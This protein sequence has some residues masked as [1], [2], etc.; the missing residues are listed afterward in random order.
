MGVG[1]SIDEKE[2]PKG[3]L[4][5]SEL[6]KDSIIERDWTN[7]GTSCVD[8]RCPRVGAIEPLRLRKTKETITGHSIQMKDVE[9]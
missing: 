5:S 8:S 2:K 6:V 4:S 3:E 1:R 7:E 9:V